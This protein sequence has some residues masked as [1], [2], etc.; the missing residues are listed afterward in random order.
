M[1]LD[2]QGSELDILRGAV[3]AWDV[4]HLEVEVAFN[5]IGDGAPLFGEVDSFLR[6]NGF[7]LWRLRDLVHYG[8]ADAST[9]LRGRS[10]SGTR[11][12]RRPSRCP[13]VSSSGVTHISSGARCTR[14]RSRPGWVSRLRDAC[15]TQATGF[16]DLSVLSLKCLLE[17][18]CPDSLRVEVAGILD[19]RARPRTTASGRG[20]RRVVRRLIR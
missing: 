3:R 4:R 9:L 13:V 14:L 17:E 8:L 19:A 11:A 1:K 5:E 16:Y 7:A 18:P 20:I 12:E 15:I 10:T 2:T 6:A